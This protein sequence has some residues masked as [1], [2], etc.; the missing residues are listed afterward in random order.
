MFEQLLSYRLCCE[1]QFSLLADVTAEEYDAQLL[2]SMKR[3][4]SV[5]ENLAVEELT[6]EE[7]IVVAQAGAGRSVP[8]V[9]GQ[10]RASSLTVIETAL[11]ANPTS[12]PAGGS[13][14]PIWRIGQSLR[15][16]WQPVGGALV[17]ELTQFLDDP[18]R[19][20]DE[21]FPLHIL[22]P[23][24]TRLLFRRASLM[25]FEVVMISCGFERLDL[26]RDTLFQLRLAMYRYMDEI[27]VDVIEDDRKSLSIEIVVCGEY[28]DTPLNRNWLGDFSD[29]FEPVPDL[30]VR[31]VILDAQAGSMYFTA[32]VPWLRRRYYKQLLK[33]QS[34]SPEYVAEHCQKSLF[35]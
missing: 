33:Q 14:E 26:T 19:L 8:L 29:L 5:A 25:A 31:G 23:Y 10:P 20:L 22:K 34:Q 30:E 18:S 32:N 21:C 2:G 1:K 17:P 35:G 27:T 7:Q 16:T 9:E 24:A 4:E 11:P 12:Y 28:S 3:I 15:Q 6:V 13:S